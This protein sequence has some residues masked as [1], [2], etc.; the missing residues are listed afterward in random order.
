[1]HFEI[2]GASVLVVLMSRRDRCFPLE[3]W[4][5]IAATVRRTAL[6]PRDVEIK[7]RVEAFFLKLRERPNELSDR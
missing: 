3:T 4:Q 5:P 7:A 2:F 6:V 1:M